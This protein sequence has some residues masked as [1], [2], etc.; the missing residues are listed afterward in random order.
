[1]NRSITLRTW[2][3]DALRDFLAHD[4]PNFLAVACPGAGKTTFAL[5]AARHW[6]GG[7]RRPLVVVAPTRHLKVQWATAGE[8]FGFHLEPEW[9]PTTGAIPDDMHGIIVTYAQAASAS[10]VLSQV[11]RDG[12]VIL[13][14]VHHAGGDM[15]WGE[16]VA[17]SFADSAVR[18]LLSGTPFRTDDAPIPYVRYTLGDHGDAVSDYEYDYGA[19]LKEGGVVRPV[20]FPRFDGHMEW[21]SADGSHRAAS[22]G[23]DIA[24]EELGARLRTALSP[25]GDWL[26]TVL[27]RADHKLRQIRQQVPNAG[28]L[29]IA[30]DQD[31][32]RSIAKLLHRWTGEEPAVALSD[33]PKASQVIEGY[34]NSDQAWV[35]AVRM[36]SEGV[37]IPRLR[38][39][40]QATTTATA[41]FFRQAV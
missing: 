34:A 31:H 5:T 10:R 39:G 36:I 2:Q 21:I 11:S 24:R 19:A 41:L 38:V 40:V 17:T 3:H 29:V 7:E 27:N 9:D 12:M 35:I 26:A 8:R 4:Q 16:G 32:A 33:D 1:M 13:D 6:L 30:T 22:F 18:L 28:G 25:D 14:E 37:D 23:D 15:A 20:F